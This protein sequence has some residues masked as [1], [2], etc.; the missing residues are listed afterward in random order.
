MSLPKNDRTVQSKFC[1]SFPFAESR[2]AIFSTA[3]SD[4]LKSEFGGG[5]AAVKAIARLTGVNE[6][7][8]RNWY[9]AKNSPSAENLVILI[10]HSQIVFATVLS[11]SDRK[12]FLLIGS[13]THLREKLSEMIAIIDSEIVEA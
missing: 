3:I 2:G 6:R 9:E 5:P 8:A 1:K 10:A 13:L 4:A 12:E 7:A 11:L